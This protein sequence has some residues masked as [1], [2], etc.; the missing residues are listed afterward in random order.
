VI[1]DISYTTPIAAP[2]LGADWVLRFM[3]CPDGREAISKIGI[4]LLGGVFRSEIQNT[5]LI[6]QIK[7][8]IVLGC[9]AN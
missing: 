1:S 7:S 4:I 8:Q 2:G 3:W 6:A 5:T 9:T